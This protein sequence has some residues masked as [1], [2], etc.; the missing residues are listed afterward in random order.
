MWLALAAIL[1]SLS[2]LSRAEHEREL[3]FKEAFWTR[4]CVEMSVS[5]ENNKVEKKNIGIA[6]L[7]TFFLFLRRS[8]FLANPKK[9]DQKNQKTNSCFPSP[10]PRP[11]RPALFG[12]RLEPAHALGF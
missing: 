8:T 12:A 11:Q 9:N 6:S 3:C 2:V 1:L 10:A 5:A 7:F 4:E